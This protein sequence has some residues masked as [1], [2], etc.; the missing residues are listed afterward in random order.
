MLSLWS[1]DTSFHYSACW[2]LSLLLILLLKQEMGSVAHRG[3][4]CAV[5]SRPVLCTKTGSCF[6][7]TAVRADDLSGAWRKRLARGTL[8]CVSEKDF[9]LLFR[10]IYSLI[11]P[12]PSLSLNLPFPPFCHLPF[13][14]Q[15]LPPL[16]A[17]SSS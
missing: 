11:G 4:W 14:L 17:S 13:L 9:L 16:A 2:K 6:H 5:G 15:C 7:V 3:A 12:L 8:F 10:V 1:Q